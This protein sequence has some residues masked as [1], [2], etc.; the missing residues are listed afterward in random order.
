MIVR[1]GDLLGDVSL[2]DLVFI[3]I[4]V[5]YIFYKDIAASALMI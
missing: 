1:F 5:R 2:H 3:C 4:V